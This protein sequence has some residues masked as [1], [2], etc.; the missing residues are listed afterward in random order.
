MLLAKHSK[1][2]RLSI[3]FFFIIGI[4]DVVYGENR[5]NTQDE[6]NNEKNMG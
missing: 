3:L 1:L 2:V 4:I 6:R 5:E